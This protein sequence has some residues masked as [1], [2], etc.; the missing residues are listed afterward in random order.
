[1]RAN[2]GFCSVLHLLQSSSSL[3]NYFNLS[4]GLDSVSAL[5]MIT[6]LKKASDL[7]VQT[8]SSIQCD[9]SSSFN[10]M[11][12]PLYHFWCRSVLIFS[13]FMIFWVRKRPT[14]MA[15][16]VLNSDPLICR[17]RSLFAIFSLVFFFE[18]VFLV[19]EIG[20]DVPLT[21]LAPAQSINSE[22]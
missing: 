15:V 13:F 7:F 21:P 19:L 17:I 3:L 18:Q 14:R 5:P 2:A 22:I 9:Y 8:S 1:V 16:F 4:A 10:I 6:N 20:G 12:P 11:V